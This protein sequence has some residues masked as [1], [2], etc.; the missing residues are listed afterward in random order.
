MKTTIKELLFTLLP[1][2]NELILMQKGALVLLPSKV[3]WNLTKNYSLLIAINKKFEKHKLQY[4]TDHC[5]LDKYGNFETKLN[6][7]NETVYDFKPSG[8]QDAF[9]EFL[10]EYIAEETD[11]NPLKTSIDEIKEI[12]NFPMHVFSV[13]EDFEMFTELTIASSSRIKIER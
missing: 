4:L 1:S 11:W 8:S 7:S 6:E 9:N 3:N 13:M 10:N 12:N 2:F 5:K